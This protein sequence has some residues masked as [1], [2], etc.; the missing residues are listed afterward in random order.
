MCVCVCVCDII[1]NIY[2]I[3]KIFANIFAIYF[4][5]SLSKLMFK[6]SEILRC[7]RV[8]FFNSVFHDFNHN[9]SSV[10]MKCS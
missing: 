10:H 7:F 2:A 4:F 8:Y 6:F 9:L 1:A 5:L 3:I